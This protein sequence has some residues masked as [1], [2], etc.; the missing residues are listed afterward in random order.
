MTLKNIEAHEVKLSTRQMAIYIGCIVFATFVGAGAYFGIMDSLNKMNEHLTS[1]E[2]NTRA[3]N[4]RLDQISTT[5][6]NRYI[7]LKL[8][9]EKKKR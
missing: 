3:I 2:N 6:E 4:S 7:E 8:E 1:E 9:L 5:S